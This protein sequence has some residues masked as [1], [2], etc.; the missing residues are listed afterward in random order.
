MILKGYGLKILLWVGGAMFKKIENWL[1]PDD[2][3]SSDI[4][5]KKRNLSYHDHDGVLFVD[6]YLDIQNKSRY[7]SLDMLPSVLNISEIIQCRSDFEI[8]GKE[9]LG[10]RFE[11]VINEAQKNKLFEFKK[12]QDRWKG[13]GVLRINGY[14]IFYCAQRRIKKPIH[15]IDV[16][17]EGV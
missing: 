1:Y 9:E 16:N 11:S 6:I 7:L 12:E 4:I 3:L 5:I 2:E 13:K 14:A 15:F 17:I 10:I 8:I